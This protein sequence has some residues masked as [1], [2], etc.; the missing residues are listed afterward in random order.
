MMPS[1]FH[2]SNDTAAPVVFKPMR[3]PNVLPAL[4]K[5]AG[6][7]AEQAKQRRRV[8]AANHRSVRRFTVRRQPMPEPPVP[9][10]WHRNGWHGYPIT[11]SCQPVV[12][13]IECPWNGRTGCRASVWRQRC[14]ATGAL[15]AVQ[16][17]DGTD[18]RHRG[19]RP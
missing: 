8:I 4:A 18:H 15:L 16:L 14:T 5:L 3:P 2:D 17:L 13:I 1:S 19:V 9:L 12:D 11:C 7:L 6:E 10:T